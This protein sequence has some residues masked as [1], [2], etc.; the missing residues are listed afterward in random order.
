MAIEKGIITTPNPKVGRKLS[1]DT[2]TKVKEF[3]YLDDFSRVMPG[4]EDFYSIHVDGE[5]KSLQKR[6]IL[7]DLKEL[8]QIFKKMNKDDKIG[9]S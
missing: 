4:K 2:E 7:G 9:F 3:Y 6:L 1:K 5:K 8:Y